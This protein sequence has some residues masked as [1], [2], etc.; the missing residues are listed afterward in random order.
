MTTSD[1]NMLIEMGFEKERAELA[2]KKTGGLQGALQWLE[3]NQDKSLEEINMPA[4]K[5]AADS[6]NEDAAPALNPGEEAKSM[7]CNDCGKKFRSVA[8]AEFHASKTEHVNFSE[9]TEE[10][11]P[12]TEEEKKARIAELKAKSEEKKAKQAIIDKEEQKRNEKIRM[13]ATKEI[14][15]LKEKKAKEEQIKAAQKKR[16]EKQADIAAKKRIQEKIAADKEERRLKAEKLKAERQGL[17]APIAVTEHPEPPKASGSGP[18]IHTEARLRLQMASGTVM[19]TFGAETTLFEVAQAIESEGNP[20]VESFTMTFPKKVFTGGIDFGKTLKE[21]G[22]V[23]S[24]V[25]IVK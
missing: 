24:A 9:S 3:D 22:L 15:D 25:L 5:A 14:Q 10:I 23:P 8:Q 16:E 2:V 6:D 1:L 7:I 18:K 13:K 17:Q 21:A 19:K 20:A 12:L 4:S 11:A